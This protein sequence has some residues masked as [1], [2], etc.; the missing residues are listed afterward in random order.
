MNIY[1]D[2]ILLERQKNGNNSCTALP[3][4]CT[5]RLKMCRDL[6]RNFNGYRFKTK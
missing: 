6:P 3:E 4:E 5:F 2:H 1:H